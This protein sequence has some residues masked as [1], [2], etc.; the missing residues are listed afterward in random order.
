MA[1]DTDG[2]LLASCRTSTSGDEALLC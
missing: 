2:T 1:F